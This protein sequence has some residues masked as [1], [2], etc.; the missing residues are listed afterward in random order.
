MSAPGDKPKTFD[1]DS[2]KH[3]DD[4]LRGL[5]KTPPQPRPKREREKPK[6]KAKKK[7]PAK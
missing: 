3:R 2:V 4:L 1:D 6:P 7:S 5:L